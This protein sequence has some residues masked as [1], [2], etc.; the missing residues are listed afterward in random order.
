ML[1][2]CYIQN[3]K[4]KERQYYERDSEVDNGSF[5]PLLLSVYEGMGREYSIFSN[6]VANNVAEQRELYRSIVI[7]WILRKISVGLLKSSLLCLHGLRSLS[8]NVCFVGNN[9]KVG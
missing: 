1:P 9:I 5:T 4:E 8:R 3:E 2:Q 6:R 7:N